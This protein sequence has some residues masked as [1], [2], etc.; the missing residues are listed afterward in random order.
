MGPC[1]GACRWRR[2]I[3]AHNVFEDAGIELFTACVIPHSL[4]KIAGL[5]KYIGETE[6]SEILKPSRGPGADY[7]HDSVDHESKTIINILIRILVNVVCSFSVH[8]FMPNHRLQCCTNPSDLG[9]WP[10]NNLKC[11]ID[12]A[13]RGQM[14]DRFG[15]SGPVS[16]CFAIEADDPCTVIRPW[17][18]TEQG[19]SCF[20]FKLVF[21]L[22]SRALQLGRLTAIY[23][24]SQTAH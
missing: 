23:W 19:G 10:I 3:S 24:S 5:R 4:S 15:L 18:E 7:V 6:H 13:I 20:R 14:S 11:P 1:A 8:I 12:H 22:N 17:L 21:R 2:K 9:H 16:Y